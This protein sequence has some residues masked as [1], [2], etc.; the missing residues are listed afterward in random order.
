MFLCTFTVSSL[1][2]EYGCAAG[3]SRQKDGAADQGKGK[4][5]PHRDLDLL[6]RQDNKVNNVLNN[7]KSEVKNIIEDLG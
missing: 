2:P 5:C 4:P 6:E 1:L 7:E 3:S